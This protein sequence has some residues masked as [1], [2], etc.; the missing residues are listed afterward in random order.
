[1][2]RLTITRETLSDGSHVFNGQ[3]SGVDPDD[4]TDIERISHKI[5]FQSASD[6]EQFGD[7]LVSLGLIHA[8]GDFEIVRCF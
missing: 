6:A 1:M 2:I 7:S 8:D 5:A 4:D 3:L